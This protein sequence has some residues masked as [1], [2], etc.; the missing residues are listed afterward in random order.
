MSRLTLGIDI[1]GTFIK[2]ALVDEEFNIVDKWKSILPPEHT[3][4]IPEEK[5]IVDLML[6][7]IA[8]Q[9]Q[10]LEDYAVDMLNR[11]QTK[12]R[13]EGIKDSLQRLSNS[14]EI[15]THVDTNL[16]SQLK[17]TKSNKGKRI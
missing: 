4:R 14:T 16:P 13:I 6:G 5:A 1:G 2:Y 8:I 10:E 12:Q 9:K 11:G 7:V 17:L 15:S 3:L